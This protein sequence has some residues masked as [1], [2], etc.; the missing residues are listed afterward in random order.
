[1]CDDKVHLVTA[2][3]LTLHRESTKRI[4]LWPLYS[5]ANDLCRLYSTATYHP[6]AS[7]QPPI[8]ISGN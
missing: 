2:K 3:S 8:T 7:S 1:M 4:D 5:T 6:A